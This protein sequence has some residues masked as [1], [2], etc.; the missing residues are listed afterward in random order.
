MAKRASSS[1][2]SD[3]VLAKLHQRVLSELGELSERPLLPIDKYFWELCASIIGQQ[4]SEKVAPKIEARAIEV[5][6]NN[7]TPEAV[8]ATDVEAF[9]GAG[10]SYS[11]AQYLKNV[12]EA[13][14]NGTIHSPALVDM[15]DE[16][17]IQHLITI[18]GVGRWTAEMFLMFTLNRTDVFS[19]GDYGLRRAILLAYNLPDTTK[20]A[21]ILKISEQWKPHRTLASRILWRSLELT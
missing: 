1:P 16:E 8:L 12:A 20:P 9:R 11:K 21:E 19:P 14:T 4:L 10:L 13:W 15:S 6:K 3:P 7:L 18:K 2:F 17:V 5:L